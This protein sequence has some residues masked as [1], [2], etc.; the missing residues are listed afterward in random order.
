MFS[1]N[2]TTR[3]ARANEVVLIGLAHSVFRRLC[4]IFQ[5]QEK[6]MARPSN[7]RKM[8]VEVSRLRCGTKLSK[9]S[10]GKAPNFNGSLPPWVTAVG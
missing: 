1:K 4:R 6:R 2:Q 8:S 9:R 3:H 7:L 5:P 10:I